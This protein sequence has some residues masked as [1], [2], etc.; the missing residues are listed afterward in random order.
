MTTFVPAVVQPVPFL[1]G[2]LS[3][4][5]GWEAKFKASAGHLLSLEYILLAFQNFINR[6]KM[7]KIKY[8]T[9]SLKWFIKHKVKATFVNLFNDFRKTTFFY[10][11]HRMIV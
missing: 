8:I 11:E 3:A 4:K 1:A 9:H 5:F 10:G 6:K 7:Q 2:I